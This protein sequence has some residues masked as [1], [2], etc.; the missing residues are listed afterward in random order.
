[1]KTVRATKEDL[2]WHDDRCGMYKTKEGYALLE[3]TTGDVMWMSARQAKSFIK[4]AKTTAQ[5][6][7]VPADKAE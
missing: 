1:M 2:V 5:Q 7:V 6:V 4:L 3:Y